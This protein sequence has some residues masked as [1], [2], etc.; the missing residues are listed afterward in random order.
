MAT[1]PSTLPRPTYGMGI[2]PNDKTARTDM[3][4][5]SPR[6]RRRSKARNE[7]ANVG[8]EFTDAQMG[9][10]RTWFAG[11]CQD[12]AAWFQLTMPD[13]FGGSHTVDVRFIGP[14]KSTMD[15]PDLWRVSASL[16]V[17]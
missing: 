8:W 11:D 12:G 9:A 14:F 15:G 1:W 10:F 16:E 4:V 7:T 2:D 13:G 17:E 3:E 5:G 6:V